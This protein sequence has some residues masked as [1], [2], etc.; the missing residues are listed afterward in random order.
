MGTDQLDRI[1]DGFPTKRAAIKWTI[2]VAI[3]AAST[4]YSAAYFQS[5]GKI[6]TLEERLKTSPRD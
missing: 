4:G 6:A 2:F 1:V 5:S 3:V